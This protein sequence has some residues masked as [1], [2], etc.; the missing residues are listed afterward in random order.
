MAFPTSYVAVNN[1]LEQ[2][3]HGILAVLKDDLVGLYLNGSLALGEFDP[4]HSDIDF[5]AA[6]KQLVCGARFVA[7]VDMHQLITLG[8]WPYATELEGSYIPLAALRRHDPSASIFPNLERGLAEKLQFKQHHSDWIIQRHI[9]REYGITQFGPSP[10]SLIDP[11]SADELRRATIDVLQSWWATPAALENTRRNSGYQ[12]YAVQTMCR[13]LY[14]LEHG[15]VASKPMA[16]DW[17]S[18]KL[19]ALW[20]GLIEKALLWELNEE[21][22]IQTVGFI[23]YVLHLA[24]LPKD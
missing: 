10:R 11:V 23:S 2:L 16:C 19:P 18:G 9:V 6:T 22:F 8:G 20:S 3:L 17:A 15:S 24:G 7:L 13:A 1:V 12:V 14:T 5:I 4:T 21:T